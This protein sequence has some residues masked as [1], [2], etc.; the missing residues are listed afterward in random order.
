VISRT[1]SCTI[2]TWSTDHCNDDMQCVLIQ[3]KNLL[4]HVNQHFSTPYLLQNKSFNIKERSDKGWI[5]VVKVI[6]K[7]YINILMKNVKVAKKIAEGKRWVRNMGERKDENKA[8]KGIK[9]TRY[10]RHHAV[11]AFAP[12]VKNWHLFQHTPSRHSYHTQVR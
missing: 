6:D 3:A 2:Q 7:T 11:M 1:A 5:K 9:E 10:K 4:K 12:V 8:M